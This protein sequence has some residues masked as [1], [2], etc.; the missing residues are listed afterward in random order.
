M[1]I[2]ERV[3]HTLAIKRL[4]SSKPAPPSQSLPTT[5]M[6]E[7]FS[8]IVSPDEPN[9]SDPLGGLLAALTLTDNGPDVHSQQNKLWASSGEV[10]GFAAEKL[11][12]D[13]H[14]LR[15]A[16]AYESFHAVVEKSLL[17]TATDK[18]KP[19]TK[20]TDVNAAIPRTAG[21]SLPRLPETP[22]MTS[23]PA[24]PQTPGASLHSIKP[25]PALARK[26][27]EI[28]QSLHLVA[29][30][31]LKSLE[32]PEGAHPAVD[33]LR[34]LLE[35]NT[36]DIGEASISL[37]RVT[38]NS[39]DVVE[40]KTKVLQLLRQVESRISLLG[41]ALPPVPEPT[42]PVFYNTA[43]VYDN[44]VG[45]FDVIAQIAILLGIISH[46]TVGLS[47][48]TCDFFIKTA[49]MM[50]K[51]AM[52]TRVEKGIDGEP[53]YD[54]NQQIILKQMPTSLYAALKCLNV[55]G[56]TTLYAA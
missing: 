38:N 11:S 10:H 52:G 19:S 39:P 34:S 22:F 8:R 3:A 36:K 7:P 5:S 21:P 56:R 31:A 53:K 20:P 9:D 47:T 26:H 33:D 6:S 49:A 30:Q 40:L 12:T 42:I 35:N 43:H 14:A 18:P 44:P 13:M 17:H 29:T 41:S 32:F 54:G 1:Y 4:Q 24:S 25:T 37:K 55:D 15:I 46:V 16:D 23:S 51:L 48:E 28:A 45:S 27:L 50:V 2:S